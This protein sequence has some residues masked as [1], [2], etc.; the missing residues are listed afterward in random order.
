MLVERIIGD[1]PK[2]KSINAYGNVSVGND[3]LL[4]GCS[5]C[6]YS[7]SWPLT[8]LKKKILYLDQFFFSHAYR[9]NV[10]RFISAAKRI[11][12]LAANQ[13]L[14]TPY[15]SIHEDETF[16][17]S[18]YNGHTKEGLMNFI[19]KSARGHEFNPAYKIEQ[20]Q[21]VSSFCKFL[22]D[23]DLS[24]GIQYEDAFNDD[25]HTWDD[26]FWIDV[27]RYIGEIELNR[28]LKSQA[29]ERLVDIFPEWRRSTNT[30]DMDVETET[31][32]A[33]KNYMSSYI[34]YANKIAS[35]DIDA[36]FTSPIISQVVQ[37]MLYCCPK[38]INDNDCMKKIFYFFQS[39][40]FS[41]LPYQKISSQ[42]HAFLKDQVKNGA[43]QNRNKAI[44]NLMGF[45]NDVQH[46]ATYAPY[47]DAIFIDRPM[48]IIVKDKRID[49]ET[50]YNVKIFSRSNWDDFERW[51]NEIELSITEDIKEDLKLVY[52]N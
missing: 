7:V 48:A 31:N 14:I 3:Q 52:P 50:N 49:L 22:N 36:M 47:C 39:S 11:E 44:A 6:S 13:L 19:K 1:C 9:D 41:L 15:S 35:G 24:I 8:K 21:I 32:A 42:M 34:D 26:Y 27:G 30:F 40:Y 2:C 33:A 5:T 18:G 28:A 20:N 10:Q 37:A 17:W 12:N 51:L 25:V 16:Q 46:I 43:Y 38:S 45:Y 23:E 4:R 29:A